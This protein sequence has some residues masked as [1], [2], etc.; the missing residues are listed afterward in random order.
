MNIYFIAMVHHIEP[1]LFAQTEQEPA[2]NLEDV[3]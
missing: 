3:V 1:Q 2:N